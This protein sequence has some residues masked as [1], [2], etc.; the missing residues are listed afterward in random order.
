MDITSHLIGIFRLSP[1]CVCIVAAFTTLLR[2]FS[3]GISANRTQRKFRALL[4]YELKSLPATNMAIK[5]FEGT[6]VGYR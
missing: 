1:L 5:Y 2:L 6:I 3:S 4:L